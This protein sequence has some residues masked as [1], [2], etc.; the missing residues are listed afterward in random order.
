MKLRLSIVLLAAAAGTTA[1]Q[2]VE[3][4]PRAASPAAVDALSAIDFLP[5]TAT[6]TTVLQG[7]LQTLVDIAESDIDPGVRLRA[8]RSLG[9]F[10]TDVT[11]AALVTTIDGYRTAREGTEL[12]HLIAAVE[13]LGQVGRDSAVPVLAPLLDAESRDLRATTARA[14]GVTKAGAACAPLRARQSQEPTGQVRIAIDTA[15]AS[16]CP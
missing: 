9:L 16:V 7:N 14:L 12:L 1:G 8:Y 13:A 2:S 5:T 3:V 6:L 15:I 11:R 4:A 10:D